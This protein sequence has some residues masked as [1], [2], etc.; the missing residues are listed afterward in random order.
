[1]AFEL[2][3][4]THNRGKVRE[5]SGLL[6]GLAV[7]MRSLAEFPDIQSVIESGRTYEENAGLKAQTYSR[8]TGLWTLADDS[9]IEVDAL[10]GAPGLWSARFGR[11]G[12]SDLLRIELLLEKLAAVPV[13][14]RGARF[15]CVVVIAD[16]L[17]NVA[18]V[19]AEFC[20]G[21]IAESQRGDGGFGYDPIFIP[22]GFDQTF[23]QLPAQTKNRISH[24]GKALAGARDFLKRLL[25]ETSVASK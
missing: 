21:R 10:G 11:D 1:M 15:V 2:L 8:A 4:G 19:S 13:T 3:I 22:D 20:S 25:T 18:N 12:D 14:N 24:R 16:N 9:G 5:I 17:G 23:A 7:H 6:Q